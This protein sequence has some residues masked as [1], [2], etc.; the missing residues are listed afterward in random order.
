MPL[1][2]RKRRTL[3]AAAKQGKAAHMAKDIGA[4]K[5]EVGANFFMEVSIGGSEF[6]GGGTSVLGVSVWGVTSVFG[7]QKGQF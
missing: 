6:W 5:L 2:Q 3:N 1:G 7:C 4:P